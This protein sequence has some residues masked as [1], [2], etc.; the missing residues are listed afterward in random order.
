MTK[1]IIGILLAYFL[2]PVAMFIAGAYLLMI[3]IVIVGNILTAIFE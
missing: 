3:A 1:I 2:W